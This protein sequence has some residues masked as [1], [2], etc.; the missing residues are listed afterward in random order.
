[1]LVCTDVAARGIDVDDTT[2]VSNYQS[3]EAIQT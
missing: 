3:P 1:M 2:H